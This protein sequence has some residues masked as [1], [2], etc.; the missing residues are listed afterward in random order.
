M[1]KTSI[2]EDWRFSIDRL[3][4]LIAEERNGYTV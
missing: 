1:I 3:R 2:L 4:S